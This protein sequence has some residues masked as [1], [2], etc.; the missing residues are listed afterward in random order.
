MK[1]LVIPGL[2]DIHWVMLKME[3]FIARNCPGTVP[4]VWVWDFDGR[5][6]SGDFIRAI[7][8]V[9]FGGY[10]SEPIAVDRQAFHQ[11]YITGDLDAVPNFHGFD[12]FLCVNGSLRVGRA[13]SDIL[14]AYETNWNY[15][16]RD[17]G[18]TPA[19]DEPYVL[20]YFSD[21]GMFE[22]WIAKMGVDRIHA[23]LRSL[24]LPVLLTGCAWD[25]PFAQKIAGGNVEDC[26]GETSFPELLRLIRGAVGYVGWCGGNT[27]LSAHVGTPTLMIWSDYFLPAFYTNWVDPQKVGT[28]YTPMT[29]EHFDERA[30]LR[31][32]A[33]WTAS[34]TALHKTH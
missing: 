19:P 13:W 3:A 26:T 24:P 5:P 22:H 28:V 2:G 25:K 21:H 27:I 8:F 31:T 1:I 23:F 32:V 30:A 9:T 33:Q 17:L 14:P 10:W 34:S 6:R 15:E 4:E 20:G 29:V 16:I 18:G 7:P 11:A 12:W